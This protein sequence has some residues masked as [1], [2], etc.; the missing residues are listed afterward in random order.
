MYVSLIYSLSRISTKSTGCVTA[1]QPR[2]FIHNFQNNE[3]ILTKFK[4]DLP[5]VV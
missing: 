4:E 3:T 2:I 1:I 5:A